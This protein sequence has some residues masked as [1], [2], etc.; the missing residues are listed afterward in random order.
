MKQR[1]RAKGTEKG[2]KSDK[3]QFDISRAIDI[4]CENFK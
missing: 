4:Y 1:Y 2:S 3:C